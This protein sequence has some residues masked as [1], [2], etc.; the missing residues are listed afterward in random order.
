LANTAVRE[1]NGA[2]RNAPTASSSGCELG[3]MSVETTL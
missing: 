2:F 3:I 1:V